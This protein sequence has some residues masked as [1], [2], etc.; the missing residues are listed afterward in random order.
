[1]KKFKRMI[2]KLP[3]DLGLGC[4]IGAI[5]GIPAGLIACA[6]FQS[7]T[8]LFICFILV[9]LVFGFGFSWESKDILTPQEIEQEKIENEIANVQKAKDRER[10]KKLLLAQNLVTNS[11]ELKNNLH[12]LL[13]NSEK[14][15]NK[16][17]YEFQDGAYSPFWDAIENAINNLCSFNNSI[18]IIVHNSREHASLTSKLGNDCPKFELSVNNLPNAKSISEKMKKIVRIAQK[19]FEFASIYEQRKTNQILI[20]GFGNLAYAINNMTQTIESS[21]ENLS[22]EI[23]VTID[24]HNEIIDSHFDEINST[25]QDE[26][27]KRRLHEIKEIEMLDNIQRK[28]K[29]IIPSLRDGDWRRRGRS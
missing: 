21:I 20:Y 8:P 15:L 3:I 29:P 24:Y 28:R 9:S 19:N 17:I 27:N 22:N 12:N 7:W 18:E 1:M 6:F 4:M 13:I 10:A 14:Q 5:Y 25:I 11:L 16:A 23:T 26:G 2:R